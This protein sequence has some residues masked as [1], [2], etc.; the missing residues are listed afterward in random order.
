MRTIYTID[1]NPVEVFTS[2]TDFKARKA[3]IESWN[4]GISIDEFCT[5][6]ET[7]NKESN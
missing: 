7:N 6:T 1:N 2:K 3:E 4:D 5:T